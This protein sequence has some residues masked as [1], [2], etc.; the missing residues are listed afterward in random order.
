[1]MSPCL[2]TIIKMLVNCVLNFHN[3][4]QLVPKIFNIFGIRQLQVMLHKNDWCLIQWRQIRGQI[5]FL[6]DLQKDKESNAN[7][8]TVENPMKS[9]AVELVENCLDSRC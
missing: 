7:A 6:R 5:A 4:F 2:C 9:C 3:N 8:T 1:M